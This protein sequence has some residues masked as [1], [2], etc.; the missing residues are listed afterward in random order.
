MLLNGGYDVTHAISL[1][2]TPDGGLTIYLA[3]IRR[4][5]ILAADEEYMLAKRWREHED[6]AAA[7]KLVLSHL[8]LA[9]K[10]AMRYR[11]YGLPVADLVSEGNVGLMRAVKKFDP[12]V[13][14]R[15]STYA[16]W[17]IKAS[18]HEYL[19]SSWSLVKLGTIAAQRKLFFNLR[20]IKA[21][22]GILDSDVSPAQARAIAAELNVGAGDVMMMNNRLSSRDASL[23][24]PV[25]VDADVEM[26]D[27]LVDGATDQETAL[28][29]RQE[30]RTR[31]L[32][33]ADGLKVLNERERHI[34]EARHL[35]D[36]PTTLEELGRH[37]GVSR[38]RV[39]QIEARA[40]SKLQEA[41]RAAMPS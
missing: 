41:V 5:P 25:T 10:I 37:H 38:E 2:A 1:P 39:R 7:Q 35:R 26:Q 6:V 20:R 12:E 14:V 34:V 30:W 8:R 33:L 27:L 32:A 36:E 23:N 15:L 9:A 28:G 22:L 3:T 24:A 17:W 29:E 21:K 31:R 19:L 11:H 16:M 13:G 40:L 18:L 4:I